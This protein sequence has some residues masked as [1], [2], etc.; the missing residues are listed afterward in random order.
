LRTVR[1]VHHSTAVHNAPR[2]G[3]GSRSSGLPYP[4]EPPV[5]RDDLP[6][7]GPGAPASWG[8]RAGARLVDILLISLPSLFLAQALGVEVV[9]RDGTTE[10]TGSRWPLFIF[11]V[12]FIAY[13]TFFIAWRGN[14]LG[15]YA[16][17]AKVVAWERGDLPTYQESAI[18]ALLP[19]IFLIIATAGTGSALA[20]VIVVPVVI[21]LSSVFNRVYRGWHDKAADTIVLSAPRGVL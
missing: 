9:T 5:V 1:E 11:P 10:V 7:K 18:R 20:L 17:R 2:P 13:E 21:Y 16:F 12:A 8:K 6:D 14:T 15:K 3:S 4:S 19:G